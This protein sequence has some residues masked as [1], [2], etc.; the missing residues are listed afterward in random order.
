MSFR[1]VS[2]L[3]LF[4]LLVYIPLIFW[5]RSRGGYR[6]LRLSRARPRAP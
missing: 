5:H 1:W 2:L 6:P 4:P 3:P